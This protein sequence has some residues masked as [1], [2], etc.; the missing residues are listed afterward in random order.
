MDSI[1]LVTP[2]MFCKSITLLRSYGGDIGAGGSVV[3]DV[4]SRVVGSGRRVEFSSRRI[5]IQ[6][7][8]LCVAKK[9]FVWCSCS[10]KKRNQKGNTELWPG[11]KYMQYVQNAIMYMHANQLLLKTARLY[12]M[13][14]KVVAIWYCY[15]HSWWPCSCTLA[16]NSE[17]RIRLLVTT[18]WDWI[19]KLYFVLLFIGKLECCERGFLYLPRT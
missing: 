19:M 1:L 10:H 5:E 2:D 11:T 6:R 13:K 12:E 18:V 16:K 4:W 9:R 17:I 15:G 14:D 7:R 8:N 3:R